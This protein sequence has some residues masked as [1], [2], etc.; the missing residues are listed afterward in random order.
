MIVMVIGESGSGKSEYA[1]NL[2]VRMAGKKQPVKPGKMY[3]IATMKPYGK[4]A[5]ERIRRHQELRTGKGFTT[6]ECY[7][8][9]GKLKLEKGS[10]ILLEC[11][12]NLAANEMFDNGCQDKGTVC[13]EIC[14]SIE[15]LI[16]NA[17][18]IVI[19]TNDISEDGV[20]YDRGT[21]EYISLLGMLNGYLARIS[22]KV[23]EVIYSCPLVIKDV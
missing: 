22:D 12:S 7:N 15:K 5:R 10:N 13:N 14:N 17:A 11:M 9:P 19:V 20:L 21:M 2:L 8:D 3:Y 16:N 18:N 4:E 1:E 23:I 6:V